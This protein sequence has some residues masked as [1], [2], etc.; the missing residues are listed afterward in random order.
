[1]PMMGMVLMLVVVVVVEDYLW[2]VWG[3]LKK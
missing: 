3:C 1:M 2:L